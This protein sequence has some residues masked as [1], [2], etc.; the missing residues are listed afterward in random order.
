LT[1]ILTVFLSFTCL[2]A[3]YN[4]ER[5]TSEL[6]EATCDWWNRCDLLEVLAYDSVADCV[7]ET[8]SEAIDGQVEEGFCQNFD[9]VAA[10]ACVAAIQDRNC[11]DSFDD[12]A[13]CEKTCIAAE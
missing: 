7:S 2:C 1:R 13:E 11:D 12:P 10:K 5:F 6:A 3:C 8:E 9:R 4:E